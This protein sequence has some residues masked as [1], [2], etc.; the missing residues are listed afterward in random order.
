MLPLQW[1]IKVRYDIFIASKIL[2]LGISVSEPENF[3]WEEKG[4]RDVPL[5][6]LARLHPVG[7]IDSH[8]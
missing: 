4:S 8:S 7:H 3:A 2:L 5:E 1:K 6:S